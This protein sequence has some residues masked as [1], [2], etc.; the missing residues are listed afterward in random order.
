IAEIDRPLLANYQ[1]LTAKP[2]LV[3]L[4]VDENQLAEGEKLEKELALKVQGPLVRG[5]VIAG[6]LESELGQMD[7]AEEREFRES[8]KAGESGLA[9]MLR[10]SYE[11]LG[12]ISFFTVGPDECKAWTIASGTPAVKAAGKIHSDIERGFIRGEVVSYDDMVAC[13]TLVEAKK[14]GLLR[15]EGK[16]YVVK[17]G[18][19]INFLFS[20]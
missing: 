20:V 3:V 4:N 10:C 7:E 12:L 14:R 17:D 19:I 8:L 15:L 1:V 6:K 18:D 2:L 9:R 13:G 5:A 11:V 16:T